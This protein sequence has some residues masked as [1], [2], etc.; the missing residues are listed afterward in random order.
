MFVDRS[1]TKKLRTKEI[2]HDDRNRNGGRQIKH[3]SLMI[4]E[5]NNEGWIV[6]K[7]FLFSEMKQGY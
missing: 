1:V 2:D 4:D 5:K 3:L 6:V 7:F